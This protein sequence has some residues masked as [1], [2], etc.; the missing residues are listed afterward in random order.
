MVVDCGQRS[1]CGHYTSIF[2]NEHVNMHITRELF[3]TNYNVKNELQLFIPYCSKQ[4]A[5]LFFLLTNSTASMIE[6]NAPPV[7]IAS[8]APCT[9][10]TLP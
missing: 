3:T 2:Q 1:A 5:S 9:A 8:A 6:S 10:S 4:L 7:I